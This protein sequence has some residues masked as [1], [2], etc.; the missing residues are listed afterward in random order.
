MDLE[1]NLL[2]LIHL[3]ATATFMGFLVFVFVPRVNSRSK[4]KKYFVKDT[5]SGIEF[6]IFAFFYIFLFSQLFVFNNIHTEFL[7]YIAGTSIAMGGLL[8]AFIARMQLRNI[9]SPVTNTQ[10]SGEIMNSGVFGFMRHPV[11]VGRLLFFIGV[12]LMLNL[13]GLIL[14]PLYWYFL[15]RKVLD[16]EKLLSEKNPDY[17][18]YMSR[19]KRLF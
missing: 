17:K 11:Y 19:V 4:I 3:I 18:K 12:M 10:Q 6:L 15:R 7:V 13:K 8:L 14:V 1:T 16:E 2:W 5:R 9:W